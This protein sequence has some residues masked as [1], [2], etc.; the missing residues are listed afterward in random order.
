MRRGGK[1]PL[2]RA[3]ILTT[4]DLTEKIKQS[5]KSSSAGLDGITNLHLKHMG[6]SEIEALKEIANF[7]FANSAIPAIWRNGKIITILK[8]DKPPTEPA[9]YRPITS[10]STVSKIIERMVLNRINVHIPLSLT[11]HGFCPKHSTTTLQAN[12]MQTIQA[13]IKSKRPAKRTIIVT[14]DIIKALDAVP[15][16]LLTNKIFKTNL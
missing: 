15:R 9:S 8:P 1:F 4:R 14:L 13:G 5:K 7:S 2:D 16:L 10:L 12:M 6:L 11:Q 3:A